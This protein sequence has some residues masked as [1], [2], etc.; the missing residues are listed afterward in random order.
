MNAESHN[1]SLSI[2]TPMTTQNVVGLPSLKSR[3]LRKAPSSLLGCYTPPTTKQLSTFQRI[4]LPPPSVSS[5]PRRIV[6][7]YLAGD[8]AE[9]PRMYLQQHLCEDMKFHVTA[10]LS[11]LFSVKGSDYSHHTCN[12]SSW[13][14]L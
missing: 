2:F 12:A 11:L 9:H 5:S 7:N 6:D 8:T 14:R 1:L 10:C 3:E 13:V 4:I